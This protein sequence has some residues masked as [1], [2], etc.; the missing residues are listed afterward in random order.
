V[1]MVMRTLYPP[2]G[3][4]PQLVMVEFCFARLIPALLFDVC[5]SSSSSNSQSRSTSRSFRKAR[6]TAH[7]LSETYNKAISAH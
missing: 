4:A 1:V 3:H 6:T 2:V 7:D 5:P